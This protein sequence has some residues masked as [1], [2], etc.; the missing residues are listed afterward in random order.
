MP[1]QI[2]VFFADT[3]GGHKLGLMS[4]RVVFW[5]EDEEGNLIPY[6][7][8]LT[9]T[10]KWLWDCYEEDWDRVEKLAGGDRVDVIHNGDITWGFKY[11]NQLVSTREA[12]Q[13]AIAVANMERAARMPN[14][15][16]FRLI[17]GTEAHTSPEGATTVLVARQLSALY[18]DL[19]IAVLHHGLLSAG[20]VTMDCAH[21]GPSPGIRSWTAGNVLRYYT[22]SIMFDALADG[23]WPPRILVRAHFHTYRRETVRVTT[24]R[25]TFVTE[26]FILPA[27]SGLPAHGHQST[28]SKHR[29]SVGLLALEIIDG[30]LAHCYPFYR[31]VDLRTREEL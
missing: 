26:A 18:P 28:R 13:I 3:H 30:E 31:I 1:R 29:I 20:K 15:G 27:Y 12:D 16:K 19:S 7:P 11:P 6:T 22:R 9:A 5:E 21:H 14:V 23:E 2:V 8:R 25:G 17:F 4:P 24:K 10:Q